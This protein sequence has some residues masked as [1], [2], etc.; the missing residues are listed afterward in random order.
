MVGGHVPGVG[1]WGHSGLLDT[2]TLPEEK[3][4]RCPKDCEFRDG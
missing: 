4:S 1:R 2:G 3:Q